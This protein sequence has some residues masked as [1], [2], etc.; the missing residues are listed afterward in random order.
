MAV[1]A[2]GSSVPPKPARA[3]KTE[4][5]EEKAARIEREKHELLQAVAAS[6][7]DDL[8]EQVGYILNHYPDARDSDLTL[9]N[10]LWETFF[11][12]YLDGEYV[13]RTALYDLPRQ[14]TI[15]RTRA[16]IQ[17]EYG[18]FLPS[19]EVA[20]ARR[21]LRRDVADEMIA[22][23]PGPPVISMYADESGKN[24]RHL[25]VGS[26]W[27][28]DI[29]KIWRIESALRDW[30]TKAGVKGEFKFADLTKDTVGLAKK[31]VEAALAQFSVMGLKACALD[32]S[33]V[34]GR[35]TEETVFRLYH[36]LAVAGLEHEVKSGRVELPRWI[37]IVKDADAGTDALALPELQRRLTATCREYFQQD[38]RVDSITSVAS[39]DSP[40]VQ[41]ADLFT[42][43][44]ARPLNNPGSGTNAK[45]DFAR[46]FE[47][48]AGF[49][50]V[51]AEQ[52]PTTDFV[53]VRHL[54]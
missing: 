31:F 36:E 54:R 28:V 6:T 40:L 9:T 29:S 8:K 53:Y 52:M 15:A 25:V 26:V 10:R 39:H 34:K 45:D 4:T 1:D 19:E 24:Q 49:S 38:I 32:L 44:I 17:N 11:P 48:V 21:H 35:A 5:P 13:K 47:T 46:F 12:D 43:S 27:I 42:G 16:K 23:K 3:K 7:T 14:T 20:D 51:D 41:L 30:K 18:L 33:T 2:E 37:S 22:D 50:F